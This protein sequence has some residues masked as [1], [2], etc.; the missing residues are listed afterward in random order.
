MKKISIK[1]IIIQIIG[2]CII[3]VLFYHF[4]YPR[5]FYA[6]IKNELMVSYNT[7]TVSVKKP[8][9][10]KKCSIDGKCSGI[11]FNCFEYDVRVGA[12]SEKV[13]YDNY[14]LDYS[15][16]NN[17]ITYTNNILGIGKKIKYETIILNDERNKKEVTIVVNENLLDILDPFYL[18][19]L[20]D[21]NVSLYNYYPDAEIEGESFNFYINYKDGYKV[22]LN[23][24]KNGKK[25]LFSNYMVFTYN[26][27]AVY[28]SS[29]Y[30]SYEDGLK[31]VELVKGLSNR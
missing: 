12:F 14:K 20:D 25:G 27:K 7:S 23:Q 29:P 13:K 8:R 4:A 28:I 2:I 1:K 3:L 24:L 15:E 30:E 18:E 9:E 6:S 19:Q 26:K 21:M 10:C 11:K 31:K 16:L 17:T 22:N 5:I